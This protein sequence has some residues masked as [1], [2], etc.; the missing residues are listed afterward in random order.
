MRIGLNLLPCLPEVRGGWNY[1]S[2]IVAAV[3]GEDRTNSYVAFVSPVSRA[4]VPK[5]DNVRVIEVQFDS[6]SRLRRV[7]RETFWL[8]TMARRHRI[9]LMHWFANTQALVNGVPGVV[10]VYD[11]GAF[12]NLTAS[13][14]IQRLYRRGMMRQTVRHAR[15]L[16][17]MSHA[18]ASDLA[19]TLDVRAPM[20]V[21][22]PALSPRFTVR[23]AAEVESFRSVHGL[24]SRFWLYVAH[25]LDYKN[26][27]RLLHAYL[28]LRRQGGERWP[29]VLRGDPSEPTTAAALEAEITSLGLDGHVRMLPELPIDALP[30]L[31]SAATALVFPSLYEGGGLPVVEAM[32]CGCPVL[33]SRIPSLVEYGGA[34]GV[35]F[36]PFDVAAIAMAMHSFQSDAA[37]RTHAR[38]AGLERARDFSQRVVGRTLVDAYQTAARQR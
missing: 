14:L 10:T 3:T 20:V 24:P 27:S 29:L 22:P 8:Q 7:L 9:D 2:G 23:S 19:T 6:R 32:A 34:A 31:Y 26:H 1:V 16:L 36:D 18:T 25:L 21:I 12:H 11:L 13:S 15:M 30:L 37:A 5:R 33:A 38:K 28:A 17:P 4:L 35:Y